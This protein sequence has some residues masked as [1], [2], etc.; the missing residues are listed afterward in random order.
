MRVR[1]T[2][3]RL[4][5]SD[6]GNADA[7]LYG[8]FMGYGLGVLIATGVGIASS[9]LILAP[10]WVGSIAG[11]FVGGVPL[12]YGVTAQVTRE[13]VEQP[14]ARIYFYRPQ[15][16][17]DTYDA[18]LKRLYPTLRPGDLVV[19][20]KNSMDKVNIAYV[21]E[22]N[23]KLEWT[24]PADS[25]T[26]KKVMIAEQATRFNHKKLRKALIISPDATLVQQHYNSKCLKRSIK[27]SVIGAIA[28][29]I[30]ACVLFG[31]PPTT[32]LG[33]VGFVLLAGFIASGAIA[34]ATA[35]VL[36]DTPHNEPKL[37][38]KSMFAVAVHKTE[39]VKPVKQLFPL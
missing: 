24:I 20:T 36:T 30:L 37:S 15:N 25:V 26:A 7:M 9:G 12:W 2:G 3:S 23:R 33:A 38:Q 28:A 32:A 8:G 27:L 31:F 16:K 21:I 5:K 6:V 14:N 18:F 1:F 13:L 19:N 22:H 29:G 11:I 4:V 17:Q 10:L 39:T 34:G 35:G